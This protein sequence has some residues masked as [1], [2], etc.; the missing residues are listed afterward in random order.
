VN[1]GSPPGKIVPDGV[2]HA[3]PDYQECG[4]C[5]DSVELRRA[6]ATLKQ[7]MAGGVL[8]LDCIYLPYEVDHLRPVDQ[9]ELG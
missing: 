9:L 7:R 4:H 3:V 6:D 2:C 8:P 1:T 5:I